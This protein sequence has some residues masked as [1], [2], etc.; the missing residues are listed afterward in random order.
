MD[1]LIGCRDN[2]HRIVEITLVL[3]IGVFGLADNTQN[4]LR[5]YILHHHV[6]ALF[7]YVLVFKDSRI[8]ACAGFGYFQYVRVVGN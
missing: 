7:F 6:D 3:G 2:H 8:S 5:A 1:I 4:A